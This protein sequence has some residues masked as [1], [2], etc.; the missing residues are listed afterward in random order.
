MNGESL[1]IEFFFGNIRKKNSRISHL[2]QYFTHD[3]LPKRVLESNVCGVC[4]NSLHSPP[5]N[6]DFNSMDGQVGT[7]ISEAVEVEKEKVWSQYYG[8]FPLFLIKNQFFFCC[9]MFSRSLIMN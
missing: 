5:M 9:K 6:S 7:V 4:A 3:G 8:L 1:R 2:T